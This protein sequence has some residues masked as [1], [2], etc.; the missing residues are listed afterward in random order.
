MRNFTLFRMLAVW[1]ICFLAGSP[2]FA[3]EGTRSGQQESA[4]EQPSAQSARPDMLCATCKEPITGTYVEA[5]GKK[6][7]KEHFVCTVC[8]EAFGSDGFVEHDGHPYCSVC[9]HE[10]FSHRCGGCGEPITGRFI[11]A[12]GQKWHVGHFT[13]TVCGKNLAGLKHTEHLGKAFCTTCYREQ[14]I[15]R[16]QICLQPVSRQYIDNY[17]GE[18]YCQRHTDEL[19]ACYSCNRPICEHLT[20]EGVRLGD[21]RT[22]CELCRAT[23]VDRP[24]DGTLIVQQVMDALGEMGFDVGG[25]KIPIRLVEKDELGGKHGPQTN[26][27]TK[28]KLHTID[29]KEERREVEEIL[30]LYGLPQ[31]HYA[32]IVAHE[33]GHA[34]MFLQGF[35]QLAPMVQEG[36]CQLFSYLWLKSRQTPEAA[37]HIQLKQKN[38][39]SVY[40]D[41]FRAALAGMKNRP[42]AE[43]FQYVRLHQRLPH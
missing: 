27:L 2:C 26:G 18:Q 11:E 9:Y 30:V 16:C 17:W 8:S 28:N 23:A 21:G 36:L 20:G 13:C 34:W 39:N 25:V 22:V 15:P 5:L 35:P 40:G 1:S 32:A 38:E 7:H 3:D 37:Y 33:Y 4:S 6:W 43:L 10:E 14:F 24:A 29:G 12:L 42:A 41:G 19:P 31:E